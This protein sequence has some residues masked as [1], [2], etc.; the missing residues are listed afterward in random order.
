M[1]ARS[2]ALIVVADSPS[3][4][5][6]WRDSAFRSRRAF[7]T[8]NLAFAVETGHLELARPGGCLIVD[9]TSADAL[10]GAMRTLLADNATYERLSADARARDFRSWTDYIDRL[11]ERLKGSA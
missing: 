7:G 6:G 2:T 9:Q 8:A 10:A 3:T 5:H 11:E 1:I 4:L